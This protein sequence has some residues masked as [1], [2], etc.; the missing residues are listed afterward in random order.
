MGLEIEFRGRIR[1]S[2][3][4]KIG[5]ICLPRDFTRTIVLYSSRIPE[6]FHRTLCS[7]SRHFYAN[8]IGIVCEIIGLIGRQWSEALNNAFPSV[9]VDV[10]IDFAGN[11]WLELAN[12][13]VNRILNTCIEREWRREWI[14]RRVY[15]NKSASLLIIHSSFKTRTSCWNRKSTWSR[16]LRAIVRN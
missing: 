4:T 14:L 13:F 1:K 10:L 8:A 3:G 9:V 6:A 12:P 5:E 11:L 2:S 7:R 15:G 16:Y